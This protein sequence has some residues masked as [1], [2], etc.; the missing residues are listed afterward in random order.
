M[1]GLSVVSWC[2]G[3]LSHTFVLDVGDVAVLVG[4]VGDNLGP[5][6]RQSDAVRTADHFAVALLRVDV[7]V[8]RFRILDVIAETV[9]LGFL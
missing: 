6:I 8:V 2:F 5:A 4:A 1:F 9:R 3:V 7:I